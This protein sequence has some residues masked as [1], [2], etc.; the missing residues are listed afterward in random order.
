MSSTVVRTL[1]LKV[2]P[3][4]YPWLSAAAR[5]VNYAWNKINELSIDLAEIWGKFWSGYDLMAHLQ[6]ETYDPR[7]EHIGAD[8]INS[9][10]A[11]FP[12]KL[13]T[14]K[15]VAFEKLESGQLSDEERAKVLRRIRRLMR[16]KLRWRTS[17][18]SGRSL[19]WIPFRTGSIRRS[20]KR[21]RFAGKAF[22]VFEQDRL[23]EVKIR[24]G[25]FAQDAVGDWWF[26]VAVPVEVT[27]TVAPL[28]EAGIDLGLKNVAATS[29]GKK[30]E[31]PRFARRYEERHA[32]AQRRGH[33]RA[34]KRIAR[35]AAR[36]RRDWTQKHTTKIARRYQKVAVG[37]L[38]PAALARTS[39]AK[40]TLD[41]GLG[42]FR[43]QLQYKCQQTG[44]AFLGLD[45]K[46]TTR[47]CSSCGSLT[48]PTGLDMLAVRA[49]KCSECG[50]ELDRDINAARNILARAKVL[51]WK[52]PPKP[53]R[54]RSGVRLRE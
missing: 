15:K 38:K 1:R 3:E 22:R 10:C 7:Y 34:A 28:P 40:S 5:E 2:K 48:G 44:R 6:G 30:L 23:K 27:E 20:Q 35:K 53:V 33:Q 42:M 8:T 24:G 18:G 39:M 16:G 37:D 45:E 43:T 32:Q 26:C 52:P 17:D 54:S 14:A 51:G 46:N 41:A 9:L 19:G 11:L 4:A 12:E 31:A 13:A 25:C 49:W 47:T 21:L 29:D 36:A 50:A